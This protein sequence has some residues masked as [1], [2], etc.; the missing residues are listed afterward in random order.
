MTRVLPVLFAA[1][2]AL[3]APAVA[4]Q[5]DQTI[6]VSEFVEAQI[7]VIN[8]MTELLSVKGIEKDPQPVADGINQLAGMIHQLAALK[9]VATAEDA[10]IIET[11][12][13]DKA[14]AAATE[15]H[16]VLEL[17]V[18]RNFYNSQALA[19]AVQNFAAA[20]RTLK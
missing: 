9:P 7:A 2:P 18:E 16:R 8:G 14:R 11:D 10:A 12:Y 20:F 17:T 13:A 3:V 5:A 6:S 19:E 1:L 4:Q 15:L